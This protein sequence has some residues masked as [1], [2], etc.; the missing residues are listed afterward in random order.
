MNSRPVSYNNFQNTFLFR[1][2]NSLAEI[3]REILVD[4]NQIS[5]SEKYYDGEC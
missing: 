5:A 4:G 3:R 1:N 2:S